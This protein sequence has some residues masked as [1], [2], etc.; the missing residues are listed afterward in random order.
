[1]TH[2]EM[3]LSLAVFVCLAAVVSVCDPQEYKYPASKACTAIVIS[4]VASFRPP[5][6]GATTA[7]QTVPL[8]ITVV[9]NGWAPVQTPWTLSL[10][11]P[12]YKD[13]R[14]PGY[15]T[16]ASAVDYGYDRMVCFVL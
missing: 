3:S 9:N 12:V 14:E 11:N 4:P 7:A 6:D 8:N 15:F 13:A 5:V 1:M 16:L 2:V 10:V